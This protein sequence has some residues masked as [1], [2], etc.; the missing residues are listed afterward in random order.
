MRELRSRVMFV[1]PRRAGRSYDGFDWSA[2]LADMDDALAHWQQAARRTAPPKKPSA[3]SGAKQSSQKA[4]V[5]DAFDERR[6]RGA[7]KGDRPKPRVYGCDYE[8]AAGDV[9]SVTFH[10]KQ[11]RARVV[12][13]TAKPPKGRPPR[14]A[15][16]H[17]DTYAKKYDELVPVDD[18]E[19]ADG[20]AA[21]SLKV[22]ARVKVPWGT[23]RDMYD[24]EVAGLHGGAAYKLHYL[25]I[26][27]DWDQWVTGKKIIRKLKAR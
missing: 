21:L 18:L 6:A 25:T 11:V 24:A 16:V 2:L 13:V 3:G 10:T 5:A 17:Y 7:A 22:G 9:V 12:A 14:F 20:G 4:C 1:L 26:G 8:L 23:D 27:A 15:R 19:P